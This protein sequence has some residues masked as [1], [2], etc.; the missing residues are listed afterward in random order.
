[1]I[2]VLIIEDDPMVVEVNS[3]FVKD[4]PGFAVTGVAK[5]GS[6]A[7]ALLEKK[8]FDLALL[9]IYLPDMD[10]FTV[11]QEVRK[12]G[13]N[14]DVVMVTA[15]QDAET[16]QNVFRYGAVDYIIKPFKFSRL[17][18][19]L[20]SYAAMFKRFNQ[21]TAID[22]LELDKLTLSRTQTE[23]ITGLPKGLNEITLK[24]V[25]MCLVRVTKPQSAEDVAVS[26]GLARVTA[27]RYLE[28]LESN[29]RVDV[30]LQYGSVGRPIK[31][32]IMTG[33]NEH[34]ELN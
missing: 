33:R 16:V 18:G 13:L 7:L 6:E 28:Y 21:K 3:G 23:G 34:K 22:Q 27:R 30:Q 17:K 10:G 19:A 9:D 5:T 8:K 14:V 25:L 24:Q 20:E 15:V 26:L 12:R 11:L 32:F 4:I 1:M 2:N 29:G 31:K